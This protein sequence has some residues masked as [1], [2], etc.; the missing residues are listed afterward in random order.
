L[1]GVTEEGSGLVAFEPSLEPGPPAG[2]G[3][4]LETV[5]TVFRAVG[6]AAAMA[7]GTCWSL[8]WKWPRI[9]GDS[10]IDGVRQISGER[11]GAVTPSGLMVETAGAGLAARGLFPGVPIHGGTGLNVWNARSVQTLAS[12]LSSLTLSPE[13]SQQ[14]LTRLMP[15]A[16]V[17]VHPPLLGFTVEGNLELAVSED[18]LSRLLP[19]RR[20]PGRGHRFTGIRDGTSRVFPVE[21][22][23]CGRTRILNPVETCLVDQLPALSTLGIDLLVIDARGRGPRYAR[24]MAAIYREAMSLVQAGGDGMERGL[25]NLKEEC[26]NRARGGITRGPFLSGLAEE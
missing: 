24:E 25:L 9:T 11:D 18:R 7:G 23:A 16:R 1:Q 26:R 10:W 14:D 19:G 8:L 4:A 3:P 21:E 5:G 12:I 6:E 15:R 17:A 22:D 2:T 20:L 13:L